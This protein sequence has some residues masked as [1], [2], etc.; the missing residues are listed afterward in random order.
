MLNGLQPKRKARGIPIPT[1]ACQMLCAH[2]VNQHTK[3]DCVITEALARTTG[4]RY[5]RESVFA[6]VSER[7]QALLAEQDALFAVEKQNLYIDPVREA[8]IWSR[9][10]N[11]L[12]ISLLPLTTAANL[13]AWVLE[14]LETLLNQ[15]SKNHDGPLGWTSKPDI[16][17]LGMQVFS[18]ADVLLGWRVKYP[19]KVKV[20]GSELRRKLWALRVKGLE[21]HL[22]PLWIEEIERVLE[23]SILNKMGMMAAFLQ[24]LQGGRV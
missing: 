23:R 2:L 16:F 8:N 4:A 13:T 19:R 18:C 5:A 22:H 17:A 21:M 6:P 20:R 11:R 1:T 14:G 3:S 7:L 10:L 15:T 12:D 24:G 9:V